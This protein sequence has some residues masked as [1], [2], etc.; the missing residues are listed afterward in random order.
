MRFKIDC[1][2][3][4]HLF[5]PSLSQRYQQAKAHKFVPSQ[6]LYT[7]RQVSL[8]LPRTL[9]P[10]TRSRVSSNRLARAY[11][12]TSSNRQPHRPFPLSFRSWC[13]YFFCCGTPITRNN[14]HITRN[15]PLRRSSVNPANVAFSSS[16]DKRAGCSATA[17]RALLRFPRMRL[18]LETLL[19]TTS[20]LST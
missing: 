13:Y 17:P 5:V 12:S 2:V 11:L 20:P 7:S 4:A 9:A 16:N 15:N 1:F 19:S 6:I 8:S 18:K 14:S 3:N 10:C